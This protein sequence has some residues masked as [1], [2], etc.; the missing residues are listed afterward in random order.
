[1]RKWVR[2]LGGFAALF[3]MLLGL[4]CQ[5]PPRGPEATAP[6]NAP[7]ANAPAA[8]T[9]GAPASGGAPAPAA[10]GPGNT[11]PAGAAPSASS[12]PTAG[13]P[14][15]GSG[16]PAAPVK[17]RLSQ[18]VEAL[19]LIG[20]Y[21][22]RGNGY[23]TD[24]GIDLETII[25]SGG[26]P[27]VQA[28]IAGD[29]EFNATAATFLISA[30]Q[31][32]TPLLGVVSILNRAIV[33]AVM[34]KDV[35]QARG[36][37]AATPLRDKLAALR[38]LTLGVTRPGSLTYQVATYWVQKAGY[39]PGNEANVLAVGAGSALIASLEQRKV[40]VIINSPPDPEEA[41]RQGFGV[42]YISNSAGEDP[43]LADFLQQVLLV[44]PDWARE[45]PDT[46][47][48]MVRALVRA[49]RWIT[50]HS[51]EETAAVLQPFFGQMPAE[52]LLD[53]VRSVRVAVP[54]DGRM[55]ERGILVNYDLLELAGA[56]KGRPAWDALVTNQYLPD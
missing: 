30:Y 43:D 2:R 1:M 27:D 17:V 18:P 33:N 54:A 50:E 7:A 19:S 40:D 44:R 47:R 52:T 20:V 13:G 9:G 42:M 41:I 29:V 31:E 5:S 36:I 26:G 53:S 10:S 3:A 24:E 14:G 46:V 35:A 51:A 49:N 15:A 38:G 21:I 23:F 32:G 55:T 25:F 16:P 11:A 34:H 56:L 4:A 22:A 12:A 48:R 39:T 6:G 45:H 8:G 37:T 28:L